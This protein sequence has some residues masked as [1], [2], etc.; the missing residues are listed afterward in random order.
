MALLQKSPLLL[1]GAAAAAAISGPVSSSAS[2]AWPCGACNFSS[3]FTGRT[4][5]AST[6][7][8]GGRP[9]SSVHNGSR[10]NASAKPDEN[11]ASEE[12]E[13]ET[14]QGLIAEEGDKEDADQVTLSLDDVNPVGLG[15]KTRQIFDTAWRRLTNLGQLTSA[16]RLTDEY[17]FEKVVVGGPMCDFQTPNAELTTV[18][19]AGATGRVG[20]ILVRKLQLRGYRVKVCSHSFLP[21]FLNNF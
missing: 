1:F 4:V 19:V 21:N 2:A 16:T 20:R 13:V 7:A 3:T 8:P 10:V 18:L 12:E 11:E 5:G 14:I 9:V 17:D 15:R 6:S